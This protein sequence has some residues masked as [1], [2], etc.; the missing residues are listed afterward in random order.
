M[1]GTILDVDLRGLTV[2][3]ELVKGNLFEAPVEALVNP[4]NC[5]GVM[6]KGLAYEF[7]KRF[8]TASS[9]YVKA[10]QLGEVTI[11]KVY[12]VD[13]HRQDVLRY[14][15]HFPT[16]KHWRDDSRLEWIESGLVS[17]V[18][19]VRARGIR[20]IAIPALGCGY[21]GLAWPLVRLLIEK[22]MAGLSDVRT[23][24]YEPHEAPSPLPFVRKSK[25]V[26]TIRQ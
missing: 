10:C 23:L 2:V 12:V 15:I 20:S 25:R 3:F 21:G 8:I 14:L 17:L 26:R 5:L 13:L 19:E 11:G 9:R 7:S 16:K 4:V 22:A 1:V 6:G 24:V 18:H